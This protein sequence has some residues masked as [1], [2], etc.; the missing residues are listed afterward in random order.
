MKIAI[1][2]NAYGKISGEEIVINNLAA[3]L[4]ARGISVSR[5]SRSSAEIDNKRLGKISAFFSGVHN[6]FAKKEF[7]KFLN[8]KRP[9]VV[10]VHNLYPLISPAILPV[11]KKLRIPV[12]MTVH[13]FRLVC[14]NGLLLSKGAICHRCLGGREYWCVLRNCEDSFFKSTGYALRTAAARMLR[15]FYDN[16]SHFICLSE[17]QKNILVSEGLP[18]DI[19]SVLA[20]PLSL[21]DAL[22][23]EKRM[24]S[25]QEHSGM[26]KGESSLDVKIPPTPLYE[27]GNASGDTEMDPP[28]SAGLRQ[29]AHS[30]MTNVESSLDVKIPPTPL[31]K[32]GEICAD[33]KMDSRQ[34]HSGMTSGVAL[35]HSGMSHG[36]ALRVHPPSVPPLKGGKNADASPTGTFGDDKRGGGY[37][38]YVGRVSKEK[39][40]ASLF[41]AARTCPDIPFVIAG[42]YATMPEARGMAGANIALLGALQPQALDAL[43]KKARIFVLPSVWYE[44]FPTVLLEAM[45]YGL[46]VICSRI[47]GLPEIVEDGK[48]GLL[49]EPGNADELAARIQTLWGNPDLCARLGEAGRKKFEE[50]YNPE[51]LLDQ[52]IGIYEKVMKEKAA[53]KSSL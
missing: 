7:E 50:K 12:V 20:N 26:T 37:V 24:D 43:Y 2:H 38:A 16:V 19:V 23:D 31:Y 21:A 49:Y 35:A 39:G 47:G 5:F 14:P 41:A 42:S 18:A 6:P 28:A 13:N 44:G 17:F 22:G 30:G 45:S 29:Q 4:K 53:K 3:L 27:R 51:T 34:E 46:P 36:V 40:I 1:V 8:E 9:D 32:R 25:R 48:T 10:H 52:I 33:E 11:C 15:R